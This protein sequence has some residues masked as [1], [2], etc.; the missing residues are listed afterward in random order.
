MEPPVRIPLV[1]ESP[2]KGTIS[3]THSA[4]RINVIDEKYG[5][6]TY[7]RR[8]PTFSLIGPFGTFDSVIGG[9]MVFQND[10]YIVVDDTLF[11]PSDPNG[12]NLVSWTAGV[13]CPWAIRAGMAFAVFNGRMYIGGGSNAIGN[14]ADV[15]STGDGVNWR[16]DV[17]SAP[18][19]WRVEGRMCVH[20]N[21]LFFVGGVDPSTG[22]YYNDVWSTVNGVDWT[23]VTPAA[24]FEGRNYFGLVSFGGSLVL[25]GGRSNI[26]DY[27]DVWSSTDG[28]TWTRVAT[29]TWGQRLAFGYTVFNNKIYILGGI[30]GTTLKQD[31]YSSSDG[32]NTWV[33]ESAT[34][35]PAGRY[36]M[37]IVVYNNAMWAIGG[38]TALAGFGTN[39]VYTSATGTGGW[40]DISASMISMT[41]HASMVFPAPN[42][43]FSNYSKQFTVYNLGGLGTST[44]QHSTIFGTINVNLA[45]SWA[46]NPDA[47]E[48]A[49]QFTTFQV[50]QKLIIKNPSNM[51]ILSEGNVVK[52]T[53]SGYPRITVPGVVALGGFLYVMD[54]TGAIYNCELDNPARW[55]SINVIGADF[56]DDQGVALVRYSNYVLALGK[57]TSQLFFDAGV[58][59]GSPLQPYASANTFIGCFSASTVATVDDTVVWA[60]YT[61]DKQ[62]RVVMMDKM[63]P[64]VISTP[65]VEA[66]LREDMLLSDTSFT[67]DY[68]PFSACV[69]TVKG[70]K[71][72]LLNFAIPSSFGFL[73][74]FWVYDFTYSKWQRWTFPAFKNGFM[75]CASSFN[76]LIDYRTGWIA[77]IEPN[78]ALV[79][80]ADSNP[81]SATI[82]VKSLLRTFQIDGG[83][84]RKKFWGQLDVVGEAF[85]SNGAAVS[86]AP[87]YIRYSDDNG[88]TWSNARSV[89]LS[90]KRP[91]LFRNGSSRRRMFELSTETETYTFRL[92]ALEQQLEIQPT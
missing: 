82:P 19:G 91:S 56:D 57:Y 62:L 22:K 5:D 18:W 47:F 43:A 92:E 3:D 80:G 8:R 15:W 36:D 33:L 86:S 17:A 61:K 6:R 75:P 37:N 52:V 27:D 44:F 85:N 46:L 72:Y 78:F 26:T 4:E 42:Q 10:N 64:R 39:K 60:S 40:T 23:Q 29:G 2:T 38:A 76:R 71:F 83:T 13:Q 34:A 50:E 53:D 25:F 54:Q 48:F 67:S 9:I 77:T 81:N 89:N 16:C 28:S 45:S 84:L 14:L 31:C 90:D 70:H 68:N 63:V 88:N 30:V 20:N 69:F 12:T 66:T 7:T 49:Y 21:T 1:W 58:S 32:G 51:W 73:N 11:G 24:A 65:E 59:P 55:P 41:G 79:I 74:S 35:L 87:L